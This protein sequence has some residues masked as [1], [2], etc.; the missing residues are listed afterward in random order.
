MCASVFAISGVVT[1][2]AEAPSDTAHESNRPSG[3]AMIGAFIAS[4]I[5]IARRKCAFGC[6]SPLAWFLTA[7]RARSSLFQ[8]CTSNARVAAIA[9]I[10]GAEGAGR[11][12][13]QPLADVREAA[14][15]GVGDLLDAAR[16]H[17]VVDAGRY[18]E[19]RVAERVHA[20]RAE[21]LDARG[22]DAVHAQRVDGGGSAHPGRVVVDAG[23]DRLDVGAL[24]AGVA[25]G[26]FDGLDEQVLLILLPVLGEARGSDAR[27][28]DAVSDARHRSS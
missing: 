15:A 9:N 16:E 20:R 5:V 28:G 17:D 24:D 10:A 21:V 27:D 12:G 6:F 26:L 4:S 11:N 13:M 19:A 2:T 8:P 3:Y 7:T 18:R 23:P 14:R 22:G 25:A 1:I